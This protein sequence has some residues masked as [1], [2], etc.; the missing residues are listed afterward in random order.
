[1]VGVGKAAEYGVL[2]RNGDALQKAGRLNTIVL[3]KTGTITQGKPMVTKIVAAPGWTEQSVLWIASSVEAASEHPLAEAIVAAAKEEGL[4]PMETSNF[5]AVSGRGVEASV[6]GKNT[7]FG[8]RR[9]MKYRKIDVSALVDE[10]TALI[11][12]GQTVMY[13]AVDG[14][15]AGVVAVADKIKDDSRAAIDRMHYLGLKVVMLTGDNEA[16]AKAVAQQVGIDEVVAEV[17]PQDKVNKVAELQGRGQMVGM[18]GDG[19]NDAPALAQADVGLAIGT[20]TDVAMESADVTLMRGS[21]HGIAD[22]IAVSRATVRNIK[23]NLF[24]AFIYNILGIPVAAGV[25]FLFDGPLLNPIIAG[26]AMAMS[27]VTVVSNANRLRFFKA[28]K[29]WA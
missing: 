11:Q 2:I 28:H 23:Q 20:G 29:G 10:A 7:V 13:L 16:T 9:M 6:G 24:G 21:L 8:N 4:A 15:A 12:Q 3:D 14:K 22:A 25:L 17:L 18:V 26:A 27:S 1:M 19:I 5:E